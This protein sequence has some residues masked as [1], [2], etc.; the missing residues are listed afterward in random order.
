MHRQQYAKKQRPVPIS[1]IGPASA[2]SGHKVEMAARL[3][4]LAMM[5]VASAAATMPAHAQ[6]VA[7]NRADQAGQFAF[8]VPAGPLAAVLN[9]LAEQANL[10][11]SVPTSVTAGKSSP[12][13]RGNYSID[14]AFQAALT[15]TGLQ[16]ARQ[17]DGTFALIPVSS[18][19]AADAPLPA[20]QV[21]ANAETNALPAPYAGGQVARGSRAGL[22]GNKD[23]LDTPF[24]TISYTS[25]LMEDQQAITL[26]DVLANDPAVR[27][28]SYGLTNAAGAGD[29]FLIR[30]LSIQNSVLFDGV[31]GIA[32]SR[33]LPVETAERIEVLKG[34]SALLNG[35]AP[36]AGGSVGGAINM[37]P[38]R[39][40]DQPLTRVTASY[41]SNG[42]FGGHLD[43]GRRFG[44]D[45]QWGVR[46]NGVYRNGNTVTAGQSIELSA[47][48]IG[49]DYRGRD[50]RLSLDAGHQ[51]LNNTA[52]QGSGGFGIDDAIAIPGAPSGST[53]VAQDWE[54][55][56][57]RSSYLLLKGE[58]DIASDW[59]V[60]GAVGGS[61]N[62]F[63]YLS[64]D[65]YVTDIQGNAEA[66]VYYW[67][68]WY[69]YRTVQGGIKGSF[70]TGDIKHQ[71]NLAATYLKKDHGYTTDYYGFT[72]FATNIYNPS[73]VAAPSLA[74]FSSDPAI[75]DTLELPSIAVADTL[76]FFDDRIALTVG[77]R[78]QRVKYITYDTASGVG[79]TTYDQSAITPVLAAV[80]KLRSNWSIYGNYIEGLGQGDTAPVGTT[81]AGQVFPPIKT[82]QR[83]LGTKYDFGRFTATASLF[84]VQKPSGLSVANGDGTYT[85]RVSGEQRNRGMEIGLYGELAHGVRLLGGVTYTDPR[86]TQ[87]DSGTNDGKMAPNISR[88]QLNLGGEYDLDVLPG[89][90]LSARA[91]SSSSQYL[92]EANTRSIGGWTRWDIGARYKTIISGRA[93]V[94]KTGIQ[95]LFNRAYWASGSGSWLYVGQARTVTVS[96]TVDF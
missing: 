77:A 76:S 64:T 80:V 63:S 22:L 2:R 65:T 56:R 58:Y 53:R 79:T 44:D 72:S 95:N 90:T 60:Y 25:E 28:V 51:T 27:S 8:D 49:I 85:Y 71:I 66:T 74:G 29:S 7:G 11:L 12:G 54:F 91:I 46:F 78:H 70:N 43:I 93:T 4:L 82:K 59:T 92:D 75:T 94:F 35:M 84:Q 41:M 18:S 68:D 19:L 50:V 9:R 89:S 14:G 34:P 67:P 88:W 81:N 42:I 13:V 6:A 38:K 40:D 45:N 21:K 52:P 36:G 62:K 15:G 5:A 39:A 37:V 26:A 31:P 55:S 83:E 16:A 32:P 69:N 1:A 96:V 3:A 61:N 17:A 20:V 86:L 48:A 57:T 73:S 47:A 33:T 24:S 87:T 10:L 30:G 23:V